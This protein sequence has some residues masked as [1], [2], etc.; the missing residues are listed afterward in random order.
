MEN[1]KAIGRLALVKVAA[2]AAPSEEHPPASQAARAISHARLVF[3]EA[4]LFV[5]VSGHNTEIVSDVLTLAMSPA[6]PGAK[7]SEAAKVKPGERALTEG[8]I[9]GRIN[10]SAREPL[11]RLLREA[12]YLVE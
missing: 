3:D 5:E 10:P 9:R 6:A 2:I 4:G 12:G 1:R 8:S 7:V 11:L